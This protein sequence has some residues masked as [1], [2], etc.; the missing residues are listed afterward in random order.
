MISNEPV[1]SGGPRAR[2]DVDPQRSSAMDTSSTS[3][4]SFTTTASSFFLPS[5]TTTTASS[6][7]HPSTTTTTTSTTSSYNSLTF[8]GTKNAMLSVL[9]NICPA[10]MGSELI[11]ELKDTGFWRW[12]GDYEFDFDYEFEGYACGEA[13]VSSLREDFDLFGISGGDGQQSESDEEQEEEVEEEEE[14]EQK[15]HGYLVDDDEISDL[16][17][18][19]PED[20]AKT[21]PKTPPCLLR[22]GAT[23]G[24]ADA[25]G[26]GP[27]TNRSGSGRGGGGKKGGKNKRGG[28]HYQ[29]QGKKQ[30]TKKPAI[31]PAVPEEGPITPPPN[32]PLLGTGA[33]HVRAPTPPMMTRT[34][35]Q[36]VAGVFPSEPFVPPPHMMKGGGMKVPAS[37]QQE[38]GSGDSGGGGGGDAG[39][40][41]SA[42]AENPG[43]GEAADGPVSQETMPDTSLVPPE[44][45]ADA[46]A[47]A[48]ATKSAPQGNV[49]DE[50]APA[51]STAGESLPSTA[52]AQAQSEQQGQGQQTGNR[53][54]GTACGMIGGRK[55]RGIGRGT[56]VPVPEVV[57]GPENQPA[58]VPSPPAAAAQ[59]QQSSGHQHGPQQLPVHVASTPS[60]PPRG[61]GHARPGQGGHHQQASTRAKGA[62][63]YH[64]QGQGR[65]NMAG[66][67]PDVV[68]HEAPNM[69]QPDPSANPNPYRPDPG[70]GSTRYGQSPQ[71]GGYHAPHASNVP[72]AQY[73]GGIVSGGNRGHNHGF[74]GGRGRGNDNYHRLTHQERLERHVQ[75]QIQ[76]LQESSISRNF[77]LNLG[78]VQQAPPPPGQDPLYHTQQVQSNPPEMAFHH[79][80][81]AA[82][83]AQEL[84]SSSSQDPGPM[85]G[86]GSYFHPDAP[87]GGSQAPGQASG[88]A[89]P[90]SNQAPPG[91]MSVPQGNAPHAS[92]FVQ[93]NQPHSNMQMAQGHAHGPFVHPGGMNA[94]MMGPP[95]VHPHPSNPEA[96]LTGYPFPNMQ[97]PVQYP[98]HNMPYPPPNALYTAPDPFQHA[99]NTFH[100]PPDV[101]HQ[102]VQHQDVHHQDAQHQDVQHQDIQHQ[103]VQQDV[104]LGPTGWTLEPATIP[105]IEQAREQIAALSAASLRTSAPEV[106]APDAPPE[107]AAVA[108]STAEEALEAQEDPAATEGAEGSEVPENSAEP[109]APKAP[110]QRVIATERNGTVFYELAPE[111][112]PLEAS[113]FAMAD[114]GDYMIHQEGLPVDRPITQE[115]YRD[116]TYLNLVDDAPPRQLEAPKTEQPKTQN[117]NCTGHPESVGCYRC[118]PPAFRPGYVATLMPVPVATPEQV[119]ARSN[120]LGRGKTVVYRGLDNTYTPLQQRTARSATTTTTT[121]APAFPQLQLQAIPSPGGVRLPSPAATEYTPAPGTP[122]QGGNALPPIPLPPS[123]VRFPND[124]GGVPGEEGS[125]SIAGATAAVDSPPSSNVPTTG[126]VGSS[127]T[128]ILPITATSTQIPAAAETSIPVDL[129]SPLGPANAATNDPTTTTTTTTAAHAEAGPSE[130]R[131]GALLRGEHFGPLSGANEEARHSDRLNFFNRMVDD[132]M[133]SMPDIHSPAF[134]TGLAFGPIVSRNG[135]AHPGWSVPPPP[136]PTPPPPPPATWAAVAAGAGRAAVVAEGGIS[137]GAGAGDGDAGGSG[138]RNAPTAGAGAAAA[139]E[140]GGDIPSAIEAG[141]GQDTGILDHE[142]DDP[143]TSGE[144][145]PVMAHAELPVNPESA[146]STAADAGEAAKYWKPVGYEREKGSKW[147]GKGVLRGGWGGEDGEGGK[148]EVEKKEAEEVNTGMGITPTDADETSNYHDD[149]FSQ[150]ALDVLATPPSYPRHYLE[151]QDNK[152]REKLYP[153]ERWTKDNIWSSPGKRPP[154]S[155]KPT[156]IFDSPFGDDKDG[157]WLKEMIEYHTRGPPGQRAAGYQ[158]LVESAQRRSEVRNLTEPV[159]GGSGFGGGGAAPPPQQ[160]YH[161]HQ[162]QQYSNYQQQQFPHQQQAPHQQQSIYQQQHIQQQPIQQQPIQQQPIQQQPIQQQQSKYQQQSI[163]QHHPIHQRQPI[164]QPQPNNQL[165]FPYQQQPIQQQPIQQQPI[166]QQ[167]PIH[168]QVGE[169]YGRGVGSAGRLQT[170]AEPV[171]K[172]F[173]DLK[174]LGRGRGGGGFGGSGRGQGG[175]GIW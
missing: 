168:Q 36:V 33:I 23:S 158:T 3:S 110:A 42:A 152:P 100:P 55:Q 94:P 84:L 133:R 163:Y 148:Q 90:V 85:P 82:Q 170:I 172:E 15:H 65:G 143:W 160:Q 91:L 11:L 61:R 119:A 35:A 32:G 120:W 116:R 34:A 12:E 157:T 108:Q 165:Q 89:P 80:Q 8:S 101:Q 136:P 63:Y 6:V 1:Q 62:G 153:D 10:D 161:H 71:I 150:A 27:V 16:D 26:T 40:D 38:V 132:M 68:P 77:Q 19:H 102:D 107:A 72:V 2:D 18:D 169:G 46:G 96:G 73:T 9:R 86:P 137:G 130:D 31:P 41:G 144:P 171:A 93:G 125:S 151:P 69:P 99:E 59:Q 87:Q 173:W 52:Q 75:Q 70:F 97:P 58:A 167:Q 74:V 118:G 164:Y 30:K 128:S 44:T 135:N 50:S 37:M 131:F 105:T 53:G 104:D 56:I 112:G 145:S 29:P 49:P 175:S 138:S 54:Q 174:G 92:G 76:D 43:E 13:G 149:V 22:G 25:G 115:V 139:V 114:P 95:Q 60:Q 154:G 48:G 57:E 142:E 21:E 147:K 4:S 17:L 81:T 83:R 7:S 127:P 66:N 45:S 78:P 106:T 155:E 113:D 123:P 166:Y 117:P 124:N 111:I 141:E 146:S 98:P 39:G 88:Q 5:T 47:D 24:A 134:G 140:Q 126:Q 14:L 162:Q 122:I 121:A 79:Q 28:Y 159:G 156:S 51:Q 109:A 129:T 103:D 67:S 20:E 64:G